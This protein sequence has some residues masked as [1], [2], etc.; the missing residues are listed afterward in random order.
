[1]RAAPLLATFALLDLVVVAVAGLDPSAGIE[2]RELRAPL[3]GIIAVTGAGVVALA[4]L[5]SAVRTLRRLGSRPLRA[6]GAFVIGLGYGALPLGFLAWTGLW[7]TP[8]HLPVALAG[9]ACAGVIAWQGV[10]ATRAT[11]AD[12][13]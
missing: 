2:V 5:S 4:L 3:L 13:P 11:G 8:A 1:M 7:L 9:I 10:G 12:E 6:F